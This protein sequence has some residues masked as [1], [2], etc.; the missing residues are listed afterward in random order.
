[1]VTSGYADIPVYNVLPQKAHVDSTLQHFLYR[2]TRLRWSLPVAVNTRTYRRHQN[3]IS[4]VSIASNYFGKQYVRFYTL[5]FYY[6]LYI[7]KCM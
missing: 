6:V 7:L 4:T 3:K 1:M 2:C 5:K